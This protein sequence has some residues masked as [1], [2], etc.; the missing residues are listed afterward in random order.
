MTLLQRIQILPLQLA[1]QIAA[2]EVI[3]RPASVLKELLE[4]SIDAG[5]RHIDIRIERGGLGLIQV[6][7]DGAGICKA[8]LV[9]ALLPHATSKIACLSDLESVGSFG[10]RGEALASI[11]AVSRL[12]LSAW[13][14]EQESGW[15][16]CLEGR[17]AA[18][19]LSPVPKRPGT[20][21]EVR[22][23]FY[24][25]PV[26]RHFLRSEKTEMQALEEVF[27][28]IALSH[29]SVAFTFQQEENP[30]KRLPSCQTPEAHQR[31]VGVLCGKSFLA[32]SGF[33]EA[34]AN[35]LKLSGWLGAEKALRSQTDLQYFYVNGRL[36]R[37][38]VVMHA[39]RQAYQVI[40]GP[41]RYPAYILYFDLDPKAVD[42]NVHP[43]K[44]EVRFRESRSVHAFLSYTISQGLQAKPEITVASERELGSHPRPFLQQDFSDRMFEEKPLKTE[45]TIQ[46]ITW[47]LNRAMVLIENNQSV[48]ILDVEKART[49]ILRQDLQT[50]YAAG[51]VQKKTLLMP[52]AIILDKAVDR[53]YERNIEWDRLG[54][55]I[56]D[57]GPNVIL[58]RS[59]PVLLESSLEALSGFLLSLFRLP[60]VDACVNLMANYTVKNECLVDE[61]IQPLLSK[62]ALEVQQ[63]N[64][65]FLKLQKELSIEQVRQLF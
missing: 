28:Q 30:P 45:R 14:A 32:N 16:V 10:F 63:G 7:D 35:G 58:V 47:F 22:N 41:G 27:K 29:P 62:V 6:Q 46:T 17:D 26:R 65:A 34:E 20:V 12:S 25:T 1:N 5:S 37:D 57:R 38:K 53:L 60:T 15:G 18:P 50:A 13:V 19:T 59:V 4:N 44:H 9:L 36:V 39:I 33:L 54:F 52:K 43:T 61:D 2:G 21:I 24:N 8:D 42:V 40:C 48:C 23:L 3:E 51:T 49:A 64:K 55:E 56:T 31:R 11:S